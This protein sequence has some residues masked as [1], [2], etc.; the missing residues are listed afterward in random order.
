MVFTKTNQLSGESEDWDNISLKQEA[1]LK[2]LVKKVE[3]FAPLEVLQ[4]TGQKGE[5]V[6]FNLDIDGTHY[7]LVRC[8]HKPEGS[9]RLSP[10]E[11]AIA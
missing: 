1:L 3:S 2:H 5:E 7:Y 10:R 9:I 11:R 8:T 6:I 4:A